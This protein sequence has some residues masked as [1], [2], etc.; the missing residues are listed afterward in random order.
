MTGDC[1]INYTACGLIAGDPTKN[2]ID[3]TTRGW[4]VIVSSDPRGDSQK[5]KGAT[6]RFQAN[7]IGNRSAIYALHNLFQ[8]KPEYKYH[9]MHNCGLEPMPGVSP[10]LQ[11][12]Q[13]DEFIKSEPGESGLL[14][15]EPGE[16]WEDFA[17]RIKTFSASDTDSS[18]T[19]ASSFAQL[20]HDDKFYA[21]DAQYVWEWQEED[22]MFTPYQLHL[23]TQIEEAYSGGAYEVS[24]TAPNSP[25]SSTKWPL[26]S[27]NLAEEQNMG[28]SRTFLAKLGQSNGVA[29][30]SRLGK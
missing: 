21:P 8:V 9:L 11:D 7:A 27:Q 17:N 6:G 20:G 3:K 30:M 24:S 26:S 25:S 18:D 23:I 2:P 4:A 15:S 19:L 13:L 28:S 29:L 12:S 1:V 5:Y 16:S 10:I 22:G 14:M